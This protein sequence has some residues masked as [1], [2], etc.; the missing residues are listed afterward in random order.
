MGVVVPLV[1]L[2]VDGVLSPVA[3]QPGYRRRWVFP[4][5][6]PHRM[7][8]NRR[9]GPMLVKLAE[10]TGAELVWATYWR[11]RANTWI[12]PMIGLPSLRFVPIPT[13]M[14]LGAMPAPGPWKAHHVAAW[15]GRVPFVWL[16]DD[17]H[18]DRCLAQES[19]LGQ[20]LV[21]RVDPDLG[22]TRHH[23]AEARAWLNELA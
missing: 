23:V 4:N 19:D 14:R 9:H 7:R 10:V 17:V 21:V 5:G 11:A 8:L 13:R 1:L 15:A 12:G 20:Y 16:E 3:S 22:L 6:V 2:D 18:V